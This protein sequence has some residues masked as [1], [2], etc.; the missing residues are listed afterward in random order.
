M[1]Y[2]QFLIGYSTKINDKLTIGV[3]LKPLLGNAVIETRFKD[4]DMTTGIDEVNIRG[5][6]DIY[7]SSPYKIIKKGDIIDAENT[8]DDME[9]SDI[10]K[11][12]ATFRNMGI[13]FD[14]G[15]TY[16]IDE[17]LTVSAALNNLGFIRWSDDVS[18][19]S[20]PGGSYAF[21]GVEFNSAKDDKEKLKDVLNHF[22][23][24]ISNG[25]EGEVNYEK[26][27]TRLAPILYLGASYKLSKSISA[28]FL[29]RSTFWQKG[30]RQS[31]NLSVYVQPYSF[32]AFNAGL[33]YQVKGNVYPGGGLMFMLGPLPLQFYVL[34]DYAPL[35]L[36]SLT[37][38]KTNEDG[39]KE[40]GDKIPVPYRQKTLTVRF[41]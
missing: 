16:E 15:A 32:V 14:L 7:T 4:F 19:I 10:I 25:L 18:G 31:F 40:T 1:A 20:Y 34:S 23:D 36:S 17:R 6:G 22:G 41:G 12:Y 9:A 5:K 35:Y 11:K 8:L 29:S 27:T 30:F 37:Y 21:K 33:T 2:T 39:T 3:N 13:A 24:S 26:F 28:G 38:E